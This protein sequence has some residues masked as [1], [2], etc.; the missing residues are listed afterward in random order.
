[1]SHVRKLVD[2]LLDDIFGTLDVVLGVQQPGQLPRPDQ[3]FLALVI[4]QICKGTQTSIYIN[5]QCN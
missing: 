3:V 4:S 1:M 2:G 5:S